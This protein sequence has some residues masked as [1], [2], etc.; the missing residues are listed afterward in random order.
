MHARL[1]GINTVRKR[2]A[3]GSIATYHYH[4]ATGHRLTGE[5]GSPEFLASIGDAERM[6]S[7][8]HV[9]S[10]QGTFNGLARDYTSLL[11]ISRSS[12]SRPS[13]NTGRQLTT[14]EREFGD[15][16]IAALNDLGIRKEFTGWARK[17][18]ATSR[19]P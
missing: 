8:R 1:K 16:P 14:A 2:L 19:G 7:A 15:L 17:I 9:A 12:R 3:D 5:P 4:R 6:I 11:R 18:A 10:L 13:A